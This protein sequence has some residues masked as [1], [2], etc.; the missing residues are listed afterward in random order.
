M[1]HVLGRHDPLRCA[2]SAKQKQRRDD[3]GVRF[4]GNELLGL[5]TVGG[6]EVRWGTAT[7]AANS[8]RLAA[9]NRM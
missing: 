8:N 1:R 2:E 4:K 6:T 7:T 9:V 5:V 3:H